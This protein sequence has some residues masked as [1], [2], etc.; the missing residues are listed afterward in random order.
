MEPSNTSDTN[1]ARE[2]PIGS[3]E[4]STADVTIPSISSD[5]KELASDAVEQAKELASGQVS[6]RR[7][8]SAG[9][10]NK[11][12]S[13]LHQTSDD[14]GDT[15]AGPYV[16]KAANLLDKLSDSVRD[17]SVSDTVRATERFARREPLLFLGGAFLVGVLAARFLKSSER[18]DGGDRDFSRVGRSRW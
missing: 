13:A 9:E 14:L 11:L 12:A 15:F 2:P 6:Q 10:I 17:A 5:A 3:E 1:T 18:S 4:R 16:E 8:K 7:E